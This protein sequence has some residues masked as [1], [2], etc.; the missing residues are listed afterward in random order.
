MATPSHKLSEREWR[1]LELVY[2]SPAGE[3][4]GRALRRRYDQCYPPKFLWFTLPAGWFGINLVSFYEAMNQLE[5]LGYVTTRS[6]FDQHGTIR[7]FRP[8]LRQLPVR[9]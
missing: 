2:G 4:S 5:R 6:D 9:K 3:I 7:F 1:L 8:A